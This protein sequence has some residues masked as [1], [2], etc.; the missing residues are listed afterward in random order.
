MNIG[1]RPRTVLKPSVVS[2]AA[3]CASFGAWLFPSFG[4]LRKGFDTAA[5]FEL[6]GFVVLACWYL[7]IFVSFA[8]GEKLGGW[9]VPRRSAPT[10]GLLDL[11]SNVVY[12]AFTFLSAIGISATLITIF[13]LLSVQQAMVLIVL[14][15][16][17]ELK[18]ALYEDYST[19]FVSLR[20]V[21]LYPASLALYRIIRFRSFAPVNIFNVLMLAVSALLL[22]SRLTLIATLLTLTLL[23]S[24]GKRSTR[25]N[26][27]KLAALSTVLFLVLALL[28][29]SR[30]KDYY[31]RNKLSFGL[32]GVSEI[33]AYL[34]G[35]FQVAIGSAPSTDKLAAGGDQTYRDLVDV[36]INLNT[37]SAFVRL[38]EQLGYVS[39]PYIATI[40]L[41]MGLVFGA[42]TS[43]GKTVFLL[44]CGAILYG[45][46]E[47]WRL[48]L[49][50]Q[51]IFI[52][53]FV[54]GIGLPAFL[55]GSQRLLAFIGDTRG[56]SGS[57]YRIPR[58]QGSG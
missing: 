28:N 41:F 46:A 3:V 10:E 51:G 25:I 50:Q 17:N 53:W 5:R 21:V 11:N 39:W 16:A 6:G 40:C 47:L 34:G 48:D 35:P 19:G 56:L 37:N 18:D 43:L 49:F 58:R 12:Y 14:G 55:I 2:M 20:Y 26:V 29:Y 1:L 23:L 54:I 33:I 4:F 36:E 31:E 13:R 38:H 30:N 22:G 27:A 44:P 15:Q 32:A 45:S 8:V 24:F 57:G 42:L 9:I 52:V 7:L